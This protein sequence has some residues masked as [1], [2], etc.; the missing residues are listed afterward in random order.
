MR[1]LLLCWLR[2]SYAQ[3]SSLRELL[4]VKFESAEDE[5]MKYHCGSHYSNP[6]F[7]CY[8]LVRVKPFSLTAA[9]IQ[10]GC[11]DTSD[12][13]FFNIKNTDRARTTM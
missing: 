13:L 2:C 1:A 8:F 6:G 4:K 12:R 7:V 5:Y 11:F 10:G 3:S 9:E